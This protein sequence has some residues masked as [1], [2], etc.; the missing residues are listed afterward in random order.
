MSLK[1]LLPIAVVASLLVS[2]KPKPI[3]IEVPQ[4]TG[5]FSISSYCPDEHT[6]YVSASY[7]VS[8]LMQAID[9]TTIG[10]LASASKDLILDSAVVMLR[11]AGREPDTLR[12]VSA[13]IYSRKDLH[14]IPNET[15]TLTVYD[16]RKGAMATATTTYLPSP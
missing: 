4:I 16:C 11:S 3:E 5:A 13:G 8:S 12:K 6:V 2:C 10:E 9:T 15:Y 1:I 7:S 14:L